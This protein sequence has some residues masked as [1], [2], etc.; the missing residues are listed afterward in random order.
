[1]AYS[2]DFRERVLQHCDEGETATHIA[3]LFKISRNT[4]KKWQDLRTQT[5]SLQKPPLTRS[6]KKLDPQKVKEFFDAKPDALQREAAEAFGVAKTA[7][8]KTLRKIGYTR[9]KNVLIQR[10]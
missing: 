1:M 2:T 6:F 10:T 4:I 3:E 8:Q 9:K 7:I 5:G